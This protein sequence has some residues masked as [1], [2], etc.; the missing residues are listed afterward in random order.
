MLKDSDLICHALMDTISDAVIIT[1]SRGAFMHVSRQICHI[2]G[3]SKEEIQKFGTIS[4]LLGQKLWNSDNLPASEKDDCTRIKTSVKDKTGKRHVLIVKIKRVSDISGSLLYCCHDVTEFYREQQKSKSSQSGKNRYTLLNRSDCQI[5]KEHSLIEEALRAKQQMLQ[6]VLDTIPVRLFWKDRNLKYLGCNKYFAKDAGLIS[7]TE[8]MGKNDF[9]LSWIEQAQL[10]RSD[11]NEVILS[12]IEKL[13]YEE[14]QTWADG[15]S[16]YLKTSK[17]PLKDIDGN[18]IGVL[19]CYEDITE[20]KETEER[21]KASLKEKEVLLREIHHR[22]KNNMQI[23][24]SLLNLQAM[25]IKDDKYQEFFD[26]CNNRIKAMALVHEIL[27]ESKN[28]AYINFKDY[29]T[30]LN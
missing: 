11:D 27:Y 9:D 26:V 20:K 6:L 8:I 29:I 4:H 2:L 19:G 17:I 23:I 14:P 25:R 12:G 5:S 10:Y 24:S 3:Y 13:N 7:P 21:M 28:L 16:H 18:I 22:V 30:Y 15:T 1:D